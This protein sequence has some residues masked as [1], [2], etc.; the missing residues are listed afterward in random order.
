MRCPACGDPGTRVIDSRAIKEDTEIRRRRMCDACA[1]RFT[2]YEHSQDAF[3]RV[4]K[5]DGRREPWDREKILRGLTKACEKR[6]IPVNDIERLADG[7]G[8][9]LGNLGESEVTATEIG[10]QLMAGLRQLDEVAYVRFAS[11]Y[12]SFKDVEEFMQELSSLVGKR[13]SKDQDREP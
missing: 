7:V 4:I 11:V 12:R 2:T 3:P 13:D 1:H 5:K 10:E 6:P 8:R 9:S